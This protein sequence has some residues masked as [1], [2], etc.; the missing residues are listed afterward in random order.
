MVRW[1]FGNGPGF[2]ASKMLIQL[3]QS[4]TFTGFHLING[5]GNL[6]EIIVNFLTKV[7][8]YLEFPKQLF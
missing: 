7:Y 6:V 4:G 5:N 3:Y 8:G 2:S 1:I